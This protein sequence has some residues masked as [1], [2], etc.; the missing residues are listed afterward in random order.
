M[1]L[2]PQVYSSDLS[3]GCAF[4]RMNDPGRLF[5]KSD[6]SPSQGAILGTDD[7]HLFRGIE[8]D[9]RNDVDL[10]E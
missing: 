2:S 7:E 4:P 5:C 10:L 6:K 3:L 9:G 8:S 1:V